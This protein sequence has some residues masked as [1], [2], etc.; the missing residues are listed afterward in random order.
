MCAEW[1]DVDGRD[2]PGHDEQKQEQKET[3]DA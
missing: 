1:K 3:H 2:A